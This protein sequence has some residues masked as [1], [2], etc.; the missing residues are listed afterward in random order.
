MDAWTVV[1][2]VSILSMA[3]LFFL[4][5]FSAA[6]RFSSVSLSFFSNTAEVSWAAR[7]W[8]K[9]IALEKKWKL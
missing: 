2:L 5:V 7:N 4:S 9:K 8:T 1:T 6:F 3:T